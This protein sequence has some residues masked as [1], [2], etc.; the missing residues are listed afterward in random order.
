MGCLETHGIH[1]PI[2][3]GGSKIPD[4]EKVYLR[5]FAFQVPP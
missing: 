1:Y 4:R 2:V 5:F 3:L